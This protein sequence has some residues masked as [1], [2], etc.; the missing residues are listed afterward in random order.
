MCGLF[1]GFFFDKYDLVIT[2]RPLDKLQGL[3]AQLGL[4]S[5][6]WYKVIT[7]ICTTKAW[8]CLDHQGISPQEKQQTG[9]WYLPGMALYSLQESKGITMLKLRGQALPDQLLLGLW[10]A[11]Q[12]QGKQQETPQL[13]TGT[14]WEAEDLHHPLN[15]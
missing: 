8:L 7:G 13:L 3:K 6:P 14:S 10:F 9:A 12:H 15:V 5:F 2:V 11:Q 1:L 4:C